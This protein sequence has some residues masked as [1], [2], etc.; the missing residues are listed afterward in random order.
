MSD[1]KKRTAKMSSFG[2]GILGDYNY[3]CEYA[4][5]EDCFIQCGDSGVVV[6][7]EKDN[8]QTAFFEAFPKDPDTFIRGEGETV[9][10]AEK[11]AWDQFSKF[12]KCDH[13]SYERRDYK[14][15]AAFCVK[16]GMFKSKVFDPLTKCIVCEKPTYYSVNQENY[17]DWY[18]E[19]HSDQNPCDVRER[20]RRMTKKL[21]EK[22]GE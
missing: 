3:D 20:M 15:G 1:S 5:P 10:A 18:C 21:V 7:K 4:W 22:D 13:P 19:D 17:E 11:D 8:Y 9:E 6:C 2:K 12:S 16:C 14:N